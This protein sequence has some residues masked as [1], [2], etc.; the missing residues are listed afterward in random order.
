MTFT[1][2]MIAIGAIGMLGF[3]FLGLLD[4]QN[5]PAVAGLGLSVIIYASFLEI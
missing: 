1:D 5:G 2:A 3:G 4:P